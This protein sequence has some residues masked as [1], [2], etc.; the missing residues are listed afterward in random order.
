MWRTRFSSS[1]A[2]S[3]LRSSGSED[4]RRRSS[5]HGASRVPHRAEPEERRHHHELAAGLSRRRSP[6]P[7]SARRCARRPRAPPSAGREARRAR[8]PGRRGRC[9]SPLG[10]QRLAEVGAGSARDRSSRRGGRGASRRRGTAAAA[11]RRQRR[12]R[13]ISRSSSSDRVV[14]VVAV[15]DDH[16]GQLDPGSASRLVSRTS[17]S[18]VVLARRSRRARAGAR[19]RWPARV[20]PAAAG[21]VDE[22]PRQVA[23]V[24]AD[25]G[26]RPRADRRRGTPA[27]LRSGAPSRR[28]SAAGRAGRGRTRCGSRS[29]G[30]AV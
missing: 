15:E 21:P 18:T 8:V 4:L 13:A 26:D 2:S 11:A 1:R 23:G 20:A 6:R 30:R 29:R 14:V 22:H 16:V 25:L 12:A 7:R 9:P 24:G 5:A 27:A 10:D 19:G 17:S 28:P 3:G